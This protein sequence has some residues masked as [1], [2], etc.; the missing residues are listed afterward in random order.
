[1]AQQAK[2]H[3]I[4]TTSRKLKD[5]LKN[6]M[7]ARIIRIPGDTDDSDNEG[8]KTS[9]V[10][11]TSS[12]RRKQVAEWQAEM[13]ELEMVSDSEDGADEDKDLPSSIPLPPPNSAPTRRRALRSWFPT[14][15]ASLF[16]GVVENPFTLA[17]RERVVSEESLYMELLA[18]EHSD[19]EPNAG[20][21]E[22]SG[23]DYKS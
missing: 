22:G 17:R 9:V 8:G 18:A 12:A 19:E 23:D 15:L 6:E 21:Q 2:L 10:V 4:F 3:I 14:T 7:A 5:L 1:M 20:A 16:G 11:R 13:R